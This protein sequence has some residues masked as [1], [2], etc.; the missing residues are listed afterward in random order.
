MV[1][2]VRQALTW[3]DA[4]SLTLH[5]EVN[6]GPEPRSLDA[7]RRMPEG[8]ADSARREFERGL[9]DLWPNARLSTRP[10]VDD[11]VVV[12]VERQPR[13]DAQLIQIALPPE[14]QQRLVREGIGAA[15]QL[16]I[17]LARYGLR[18]LDE[19]GATLDVHP[20]SS[21]PSGIPEKA[22]ARQNEIDVAS[23]P[24]TGPSLTVTQ[25]IGELSKHPPEAFVVFEERAGCWWD[26]HEVALVRLSPGNPY[27]EFSDEAD[28]PETSIVV[29]R[30]EA[31]VLYEPL[32]DDVEFT[33]F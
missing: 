29:L 2:L 22:S 11:R 4:D 19:E 20:V 28:Q 33:G 12:Q 14:L 32:E 31:S 10:R 3:L 9:D 24:I 6:P 18:R 13:V 26:F 27:D 1:A 5:A 21:K 25:L 7:A 23:V 17:S 16:V 15:S 8:L 30:G